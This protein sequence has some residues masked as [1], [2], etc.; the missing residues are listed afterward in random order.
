M[1]KHSVKHYTLSD[2]SALLC[3]VAPQ[4]TQSVVSAWTWAGSRFDP[5][6]QEGMAHFL[7]HLLMQKTKRFTSE[8]DRFLHLEERG[9]MYNANTTLETAYYHQT[10]LSEYTE[11]SF[12]LLRSGIQESTVTKDIMQKEKK[13]V[14]NEKKQTE[15]DPFTRI[16]GL[17]NAA[18]FDKHPLGREFFGT[19][20]SIRNFSISGIKNFKNKHLSPKSIQY[21]IVVPDTKYIKNVIATTVKKEREILS[22]KNNG[23]ILGKP[24]K[25]ERRELDHVVCSVGFRTV[26]IYEWKASVTLHLIR[27]YLSNYWTSRLVQRLR[28]EKGLTYWVSGETANFSDTGLIRFTWSSSAQKVGTALHILLEEVDFLKKKKIFE[29]DLQRIKTIFLTSLSGDMNNLHSVLWYYG[30]QYTLGAQIRSFDE[31]ARTV[32]D[33]SSDDIL[34]IAQTYLTYERQSI[35]AI[36]NIDKKGIERVI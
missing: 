32:R 2:E 22:V 23:D 33:I 5:V 3:V 29:R 9:I 30:V 20:S 6:G 11:E 35:V 14:V 26:P 1:E 16:S 4:L 18:L 27:D 8:A 28:L 10:Q 12:D 24:V 36:G 25:I 34:R 31:F 13:D 17:S 21:V 15:S 7:E 19:A